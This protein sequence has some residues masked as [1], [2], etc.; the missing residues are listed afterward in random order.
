[1]RY[2]KSIPW[3][4]F[5][6]VGAAFVVAL[7]L[8]QVEAF[9]WVY[10]FSRA[11]EDWELDELLMTIPALAIFGCALAYFRHR[12][13]RRAMVAKAQVLHTLAQANQ[14]LK[15]LRKHQDDFMSAV[16]HELRTPMHHV[17]SL[18]ELL[19]DPDLSEEERAL[20]IAKASEAAARLQTQ[21]EMVLE[22]VSLG[23][24]EWRC[25]E[26]PFSPA[27]QLREIAA[28]YTP[29]VHAADATISVSVQDDIPEI[30]MGCD[31]VMRRCIELLLDNAIKFAKGTAIT[32]RLKHTVSSP[33]VSVLVVE[34][35][36]TGPGIPHDHQDTVF[37]P[38]VQGDGGV[39]RQHGGLGMG[40][41]VVHRM[42]SL[43]KGHVALESQPGQGAS[44]RVS[45]PI[46]PET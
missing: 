11:H 24:H 10:A 14:E 3:D 27:V 38:L 5:I 32:L 19:E 17:H 35:A 22:F 15:R 28:H 1:M 43:A 9:E 31:T 33:E 18:L 45:I 30:V 6:A 40:L 12:A 23:V 7:V 25:Q 37:A 29:K 39:S 13:M 4:I 16:T 26:V 2:S 21:L 42:A 46:R 8:M 44:F 41:A 34:V 20:Y 36:D